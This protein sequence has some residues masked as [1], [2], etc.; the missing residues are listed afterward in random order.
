[1]THDTSIRLFG[2]LV[3]VGSGVEEVRFKDLNRLVVFSYRL[4]YPFKSVSEFM[5]VILILASLYCI[6]IRYSA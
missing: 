5:L 1:M 6:L 3:A 2:L 4:K